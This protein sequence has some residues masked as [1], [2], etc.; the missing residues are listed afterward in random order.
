MISRVPQIRSNY[1]WIF[2]KNSEY[3]YFGTGRCCIVFG[4]NRNSLSIQ[5]GGTNFEILNVLAKFLN[6]APISKQNILL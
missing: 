6:F 4:K 3:V 2:I 5:N 1:Y